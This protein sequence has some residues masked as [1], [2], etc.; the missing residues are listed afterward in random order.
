MKKPRIAIH[1]NPVYSTHSNKWHHSWI[2]YCQRNKLDYEVVDCFQNNILEKL[3]KFD[4]LLWH[5]SNY[6]IQ[7][8]LFAR[9]ILNAA[10]K[11]GLN[12]FPDFNTSWHFD[13][14]I[15]EYYLLK[16]VD[17]PIPESWIF[18]TKEESIKWLKNE[19]LYPLV[20]KLKSGSGSN[21]VRL[22]HNS[23]QAIA[24]A[25]KMF[26][27]GFKNVPGVLFKA[28]SN[29]RS[30]KNKG[31]FVKRFKRIPDFIQTL[32]RAKMLNRERGYAYFQEFVPNDGYD[33][34]IIVIGDK[35]SFIGRKTRKEDFRASGGGDLCFDKHLVT[36]EIIGSAFNLSDKL[37]FQCM[38]YDFVVDKRTNTGKVVEISYGFSHAALL[39]A[40]GYWARDGNW[41]EEPLNAPEEVINN[42]ICHSI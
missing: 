40:G 32:S 23:A 15:A 33:L 10:V 42:L 20:A 25:D 8:M 14:K 37:N 24:Y 6:I 22:L 12:V 34:K 26:K 18:F 16:A 30:A 27:K 39:Q 29:I 35:L 13:D 11:N 5:F 9:S 41:H 7:D 36:S 3:N 19:A 1:I 17:A 4:Y 31:D 38:G 21:N 28:S 2:E